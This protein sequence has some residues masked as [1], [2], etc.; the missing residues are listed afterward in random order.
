MM[1]LV[2]SLCLLLP[3]LAYAEG[4][5]KV[6]S[7]VREADYT[8]GSVVVQQIDVET[9][10]GY[11]LDVGSLPEKGQTEAIELRDAQWGA[12]DT[13]AVSR[14]HIV[15]HWQIFVA[16]DN[17]RVYPLK[18]LQL[19]FM[20]KGKVLVVSVAANKVI[21]SSLL[22]A[23]LD[24]HL[25]QPYPDVTPPPIELRAA[26]LALG[27][28]LLAFVLAGIYFAHYF[29][30]LF[31]SSAPMHFRAAAR[32]IRRLRLGNGD[33]RSALQRLTRAFDAYA[34]RAVSSEQLGALLAERPEMTALEREIGIFYRDV[35]HVF[36]AGAQP[37]HDIEALELLARRLC[38][39]EAA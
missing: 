2:L 11:R 13:G 25:V 10:L 14:H 19:Q 33:V 6:H 37:L 7:A 8:I 30:W 29:G 5:V 36:F 1:R 21:V 34:G 4:T 26:W 28:G 9:P 22:P 18:P 12:H 15:L 3:L 27:G 38:R 16:S 24:Q 32:D 23:K 17:T 39:V 31:Q 20:R 35:Q